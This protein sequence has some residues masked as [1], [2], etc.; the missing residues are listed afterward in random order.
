MDAQ[1]R[2][3][4]KTQGIEMPDDPDEEIVMGDKIITTY[5]FGKIGA[6]LIAASVIGGSALLF[7]LLSNWNT[8]EKPSALDVDTNISTDLE[9]GFGESKL[10]N[11]SE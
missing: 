11:E 4:R 9:T 8:S 6:A 5:D 7:G 2:A 3:I 1:Q 10:F